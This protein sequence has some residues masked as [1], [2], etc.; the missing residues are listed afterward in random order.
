VFQGA[1]KFYPGR[2]VSVLDADSFHQVEHMVDKTE[3]FPGD[4]YRKN[5]EDGLFGCTILFIGI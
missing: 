4:D 3:R 1:P 5:A 2:Q